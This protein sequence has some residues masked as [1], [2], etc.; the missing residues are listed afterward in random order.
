MKVVPFCY[1]MILANG[2]DGRKNDT[3]RRLLL[4]HLDWLC[5]NSYLASEIECIIISGFMPQKSETSIRWRLK[6]EK[7][8]MMWHRFLYFYGHTHIS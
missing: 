5:E 1:F 3:S 6:L 4:L 8:C 7:R 2:K